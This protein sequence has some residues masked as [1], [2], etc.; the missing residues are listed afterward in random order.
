MTWNVWVGY[1]ETTWNKNLEPVSY[2]ECSFLNQCNCDW[3]LAFAKVCKPR[4]FRFSISHMCTISS[5]AYCV[6]G[7]PE[8][9]PLWAHQEEPVPFFSCHWYWQDEDRQF[10]EQVERNRLGDT[11]IHNM[12]KLNTLVWEAH[13]NVLLLRLW[14]MSFFSVCNTFF[15][16]CLWIRGNM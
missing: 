6:T 8:G 12:Q 9:L 3:N 11:F 13:H 5:S 2:Q 14:L 15:F 10:D 4:S 1:F 16:C 7:I